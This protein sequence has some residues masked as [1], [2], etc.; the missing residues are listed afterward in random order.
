VAERIAGAFG[1][2]GGVPEALFNNASTVILERDAYGGVL[3]RWRPRLVALADEYGAG[4][5]RCD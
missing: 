4:Q 1:Y 3:H 5:F 2:F